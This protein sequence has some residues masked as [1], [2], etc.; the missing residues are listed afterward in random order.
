MTSGFYLFIL[1]IYF[2]FVECICLGRIGLISLSESSIENKVTKTQPCI[3][4]DP[5][6]RT[7]LNFI[8]ISCWEWESC[9]LASIKKSRL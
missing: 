2:A 1:Y 6:G 4:W 3:K 5:L 9:Y 7:T 8:E